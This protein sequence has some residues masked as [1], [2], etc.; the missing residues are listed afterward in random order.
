MKITQAIPTNEGAGV[1]LRRAIGFCSPYGC[2]APNRRIGKKVNGVLLDGTLYRSQLQP[3]AWLD[4][5]GAVK[6]TFVDGLHGNVPEYMVQGGTTNHLI[7][8]QVGSVRLVVNTTTG[9]VIEQI[10]WDEFGNVLSDTAPGTQPFSGNPFGPGA[11]SRGVFLPGR[12][13]VASDD[14]ACLESWLLQE[15]DGPRPWYGV[16]GVG[17]NC[18]PWADDAFNSCSRQCSGE[19]K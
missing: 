13:D 10:D 11:R 2:D 17:T 4:G 3:A 9:A 18:Q 7:S 8:D 15:C 5:S 6:V 12:C 1:R 16:T 14:N 19:S